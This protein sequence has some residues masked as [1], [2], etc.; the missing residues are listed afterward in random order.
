MNPRVI[1]LSFWESPLCSLLRWRSNQFIVTEHGSIFLWRNKDRTAELN[2]RWAFPVLCSAFSS[3]STSV[4]VLPRSI[5]YR[6]LRSTLDR[7]SRSFSLGARSPRW[8]INWMS[9]ETNSISCFL[10]FFT[11]YSFSPKVTACSC[12]LL[13]NNYLSSTVWSVHLSLKC[14]LSLNCYLL[15]NFWFGKMNELLVDVNVASQIENCE[16]RVLRLRTFSKIK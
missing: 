13:P 5:P 11:G 9:A 16:T 1:P 10:F 6:R 15:L 8:R 12:Y 4:S 7:R 14:Y 2:R 3:A